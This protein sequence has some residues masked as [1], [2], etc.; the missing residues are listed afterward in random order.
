MP[1]TGATDPNAMAGQQ[2]P[3]LGTES[4]QG[5]GT[6][7]SPEA[8]MPPMAPG[9][10]NTTM[11]LGQ[12]AAKLLQKQQGTKYA[13]QLLQH[14]RTIMQKLMASEMLGNPQAESDIAT[15]IQKL[16]SAGE[17]LGKT[18]PSQSPALTTSLADMV[19]RAGGGTAGATQ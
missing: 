3:A 4:P 10:P 9:G 7:A 8:G 11:Q 1:I 16:S 17:K 5:S 2:A 15:I 13:Q 19:G 18:G 12:I 14:V 6:M